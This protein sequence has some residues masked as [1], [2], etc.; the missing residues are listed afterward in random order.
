MLDAI[1]PLLD[2]GILNEE[3]KTQIQE[4][5]NS[6]L[7]EAKSELRSE[8]ANRYEHDKA[9]MVEAL[10]K[11]V[12]ETLA[13]EVAK[14]SEERNQLVADRAK[15]VTEM[16]NKAGKFDKFLQESL[17]KELLEFVNDRMTHANAMQKLE[18]F[19]VRALAEELSEFAEDKKDLINTKVK[20]VS[21]ANAKFEELRSQFVA[22]SSKLV[23]EAVTKT[24]R[25]E[26]GQLKEDINAA[27]QNSFG[28]RIFE[29]FA[30]EFSATHL[31]EHAEIRKLKNDMAAMA[32]KLEEAANAVEEKSALVE[33]KN[34]EIANINNNITRQNKLNELMK[35]LAA[36]KA[37]V[38]ASL[39]ESVSTE[40][41]ET[42]FQKYLPAVLNGSKVEG[43]K[44]INE[45]VK[46]VTGD[47]AKTK[48][49]DSSDAD[50][51]VEIRRLAGLAK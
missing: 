21:E 16:S 39:L 24:M 50:N 28:R 34:R 36:D 42:S 4:A 41:L 48:A 19:V 45:S 40:K 2:S 11:M 7:E 8:F 51:I 10:D 9:V 37:A 20:L 38:M 43:R 1:K 35:P 12:T 26:I 27:R 49:Q 25:A 6:K 5:W 46:E 3:A 31:N 15:F 33:A 47:R 44:A 22:R 32:A 23:Q 13:E 29:A 17:H 14:I 30:S 18:K